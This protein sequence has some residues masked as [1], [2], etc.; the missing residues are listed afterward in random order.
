MAGGVAGRPAGERDPSAA[1]AGVSNAEIRTFMV[2]D[3]PGMWR[4]I[5]R[6]AWY[7][8]DAAMNNP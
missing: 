7:Q 6:H 1:L 8:D 5:G 2:R 4:R 3:R